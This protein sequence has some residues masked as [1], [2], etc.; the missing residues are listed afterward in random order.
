M[1]RIKMIS[2]KIGL[3]F[4][5]LNANAEVYQEAATAAKL[6]RSALVALENLSSLTDLEELIKEMSN[7]WSQVDNLVQE[8]S[9]ADFRIQ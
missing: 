9:S 8:I 6:R 3:M 2:E 7:N 5:I 1:A 4:H